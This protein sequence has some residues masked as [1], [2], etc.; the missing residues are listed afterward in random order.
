LSFGVVRLSG[1]GVFIEADGEVERLGDDWKGGEGFAC[2]EGVDSFGL[3]GF[4]D[5]CNVEDVVLATGSVSGRGFIGSETAAGTLSM[6]ETGRS[7][8]KYAGGG[9][10][11]LS[12][13]AVSNVGGGFSKIDLGIL[14]GFGFSGSA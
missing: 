4:S 10:S 14:N 11:G 6:G 12:K 3:S 1:G 9:V 13:V 2:S 5:F 8:V 7:V